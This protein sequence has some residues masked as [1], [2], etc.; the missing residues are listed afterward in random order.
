VLVILGG[1]DKGSDLRPV[2]D[3]AARRTRFAACIGTTGPGLAEAVRNAGGQSAFYPDLAAAVAACRQRAQPGDVVLLS[4]AC[5]SWDQFTDY[6]A[7][8]AAFARLSLGPE[9]ERRG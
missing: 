9:T 3:E 2:A 4:P 8:G 5:A 1:Y 7:R 6:R